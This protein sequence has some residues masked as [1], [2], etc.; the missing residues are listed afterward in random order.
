M[1]WGRESFD[2]V[3]ALI[4]NSWMLSVAAVLPQGFGHRGTTHPSPVRLQGYLCHSTAAELARVAPAD[5]LHSGGPCPQVGCRHGLPRVTDSPAYSV[6][7]KVPK[8]AWTWMFLESAANSPKII[9]DHL[10]HED[11]LSNLGVLSPEETQGRE[12]LHV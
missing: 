10:S 1:V 2:A 12:H 6:F 8:T 9:K 7:H 4:S 11:S 3:Q 5:S